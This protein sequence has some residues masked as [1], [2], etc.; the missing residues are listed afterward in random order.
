MPSPERADG[1]DVVLTA[2]EA[3]KLLRVSRS[4]L[5]AMAAAQ[6]IPHLRLSTRC[7]RF[8]RSSL[9]RWLEE[10]EQGG[11]APPARVRAIAGGKGG[12]AQ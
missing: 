10:R 2:V 3:A 1:D 7:V 11:A 5:Y 8:C 9:L 6:E 12:A 4:R